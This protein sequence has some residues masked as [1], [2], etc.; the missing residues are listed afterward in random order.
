MDMSDPESKPIDSSSEEIQL[1]SLT[2]EFDELHELLRER[3][4]LS[5]GRL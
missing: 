2:T 1:I 3:V 4:L 5:I